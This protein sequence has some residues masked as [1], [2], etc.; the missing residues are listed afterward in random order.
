MD[1]CSGCMCLL[2]EEGRVESCTLVVCREVL[3]K[4]CVAQE[5]LN[6]EAGKV[7]GDVGGVTHRGG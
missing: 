5:H 7:S 2:L 6:E 1:D 3:P 4:R